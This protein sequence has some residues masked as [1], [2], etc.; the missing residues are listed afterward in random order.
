MLFFAIKFIL[1]VFY[2]TNFLRGGFYRVAAKA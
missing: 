2:L 1:I